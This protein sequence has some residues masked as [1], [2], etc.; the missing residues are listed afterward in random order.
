MGKREMTKCLRTVTGR[1]G[2]GSHRR[3]GWLVGDSRGELMTQG[4]E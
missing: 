4:V 1:A 3:T 2:G